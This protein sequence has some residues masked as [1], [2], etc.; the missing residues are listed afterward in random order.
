[1]VRSFNQCRAISITRP[2][3]TVSNCPKITRPIELNLSRQ[4]TGNSQV[5]FNRKSPY[6]DLTPPQ[7]TQS[8]RHRA[9]YDTITQTLNHAEAIFPGC[10]AFFTIPHY[11]TIF[12]QSIN[13]VPIPAVLPS[14][15]TPL[16]ALCICS[17]ADD[18]DNRYGKYLSY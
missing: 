9:Y 16:R 6:S 10:H 7:P 18:G 4:L 15:T 12:P 11:V 17:S 2:P 8:I 1:M 13:N 5:S 3:A 14:T